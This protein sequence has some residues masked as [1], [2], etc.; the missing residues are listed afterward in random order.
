VK[1]LINTLQKTQNYLRWIIL[2]GL[3]SLITFKVAVNYIGDLKPNIGI[4]QVME[5]DQQDETELNLIAT[6]SLS[7]AFPSTNFP[8]KPKK[9]K[10]FR[11]SNLIT[12]TSK[13]TED[14][15]PEQ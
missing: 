1:N 3:L 7:T 8:K 15:P 13:G 14:P 4:E 6:I 9:K 10:W 5:E 2:C 11:F 12:S